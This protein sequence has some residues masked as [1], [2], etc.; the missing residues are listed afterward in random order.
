MKSLVGYTGFVGSNIADACNFDCLY[1]SKNIAEAYGTKPD[2]LVYSGVRAE[3]FIAN[4]VPDEDMKNILEAFENIEKIDP[5]RLVL[6]ST[7]DVFKNPNWK[8][9]DDIPEKENLH[10]YGYNRLILEEKVREKYK[11][12]L[13]IR[14]PGLF[15]ENLKKNFLFDMIQIYPSMLNEEKY[16]KYC[17]EE[18]KKFYIKQN[19][20]FYKCKAETPEEKQFLRE[21]FACS[22]FNALNFTDSRGVFQFYP[23]EM[24]W[25]HIRIALENDLKLVHMA[26]EPLKASDIFEFVRGEKFENEI[27]ENPPCYDFK[28]QYAEL[29]GG[30]GGYILT[31]HTVLEKIKNFIDG[32]EKR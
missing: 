20:G 30:N 28:T 1:N 16:N 2:L 32:V 27:S 18:I 31:A 26:V 21:Y 24:L 7:V 11:D 10:A 19:N 22:Q 5:K 6:I 23:L 9:E 29:F 8:D 15:G 13:I 3:K 17:N 4:N 14:L 12:A 25:D